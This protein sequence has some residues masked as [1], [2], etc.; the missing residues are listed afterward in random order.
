MELNDIL[1]LPLS[2]QVEKLS[3]QLTDDKAIDVAKKQIDHWQHDVHNRAIRK[4]KT[5]VEIE[6][7]LDT[8]GEPTG[9]KKSKPITTYVNRLSYPFQ[10]LIT[11]L[12]TEFALGN[13]IKLSVKGDSA[14]KDDISGSME[15][16]YD[17]LKIDAF[18]KDMMRKLLSC[19]EVAE[20]IYTTEGQPHEK[21]GFRTP[22]KM[23]FQLFSP[24]KGDKLYPLFDRYGNMVA[25]SRGFTLKEDD[26]DVEHLETWTETNYFFFTKVDAGWMKEVKENPLGKIP[27]VY[28]RMDKTVWDGVQTQIDRYEKFSSNFADMNDRHAWPI[29]VGKGVISSRIGDF[30]QIDDN[31]ESQ[32]DMKYVESNQAA[33]RIK[34]EFEKLNNEIF[35]LTQSVNLT[36]ENV[37]GIGNMASGAAL[38]VLLFNPHLKVKKHAEILDPHFARRHS[39]LLTYLS[40]MNT[41]WAA[42][43]EKVEV[44]TKITPLM[45]NMMLE[46]IQGISQS[47]TNQTMSVAT[48]TKLNPLIEDATQ[49]LEELAKQKEDT[50]QKAND[51]VKVQDKQLKTA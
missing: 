21:Y 20:Y 25:F 11:E 37:R 4:D 29:L 14:K 23:G 43:I 27:I 32:G 26:K 1:K 38:N 16:I 41:S 49:E 2:E 31:G 13:N 6:D 47:I 10:E 12:H 34:L 50:A 51:V 9:G 44:T 8:N 22:V 40:M 3:V 5:T 15:A 17:R 36:L 7:E 46:L 45:P 33:E 39:I 48:G 19:F 42:D 35:G 24:L 18:N 30:V 28:S